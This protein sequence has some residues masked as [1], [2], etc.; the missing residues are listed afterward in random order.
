MEFKPLE[1]TELQPAPP[2]PRGNPGPI[3]GDEYPSVM[4]DKNTIYCWF[5]FQ[6]DSDYDLY[7]ELI[8][9]LPDMLWSDGWGHWIEYERE[10]CGWDFLAGLVDHWPDE[11]PCVKGALALGVAPNQPFLLRIEG[12]YHTSTDWET[13]YKESELDCAWELIAI[14]P[15]SPVQVEAEWQ[16]WRDQV[17]RFDKED[18]NVPA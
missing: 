9:E 3:V 17:D 7:L 8:S 10:M 5:E 6:L 1:F 15:M 12:S 13:G 11:L 2:R 16:A 4:V 18:S 14:E